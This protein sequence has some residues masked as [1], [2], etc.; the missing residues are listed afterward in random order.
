V[1]FREPDPARIPGERWALEDA[2]CQQVDCIS[3]R[4]QWQIPYCAFPFPR[5][6]RRF[7]GRLLLWCAFGRGSDLPGG[8]TVDVLATLTE[9]FCGGLRLRAMVE[10]QENSATLFRSGIAKIEPAAHGCGD[11]SDASY[12]GRVLGGATVNLKNE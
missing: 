11:R 5:T 6:S 8:V 1:P 4:G 2:L 9:N 3:I 10:S 7:I 12:P